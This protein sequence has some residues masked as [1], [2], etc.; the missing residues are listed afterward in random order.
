VS[1]D[2]ENDTPAALRAHAARFDRNATAWRF[3]TAPAP[4]V[5][6]FAA[7]F[8]VSVI[9]EPDGTITHNL[10]TAV[11]GPDG[12]VT[13]IWSGSDWTASDLVNALRS[14]LGATD[15]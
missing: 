2:P 11:F 12:R 8:G 1:F 13:A 9:R 6:R 10:R 14:A 3:A 15:S 4:D 5:D 7:R